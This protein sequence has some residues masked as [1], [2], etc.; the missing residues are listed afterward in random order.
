[1]RNTLLKNLR[2]KTIELPAGPGKPPEK[3]TMEEL[4][5]G[6]AILAVETRIVQDFPIQNPSYEGPQGGTPGYAMPGMSGLSAAMDTPVS[7]PTSEP[8]RTTGS[9]AAEG[10]AKKPGE[11]A[12]NPRVFLVSKY[13]FVVQFSWREATLSDRLQKRRQAA[14]DATAPANSVVAAPPGG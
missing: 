6:F 4:G 7:T 3:F 10:T 14:Q 1:V 2:E 12:S 5:I 13:T 9:G 8:G 11:D